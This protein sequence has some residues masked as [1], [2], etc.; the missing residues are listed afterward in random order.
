MI[1]APESP[2]WLVRH[3]MLAEAERSAT[4]LSS[5]ESARHAHEQVA[6][7]VCVTKLEQEETEA[8]GNSSWIELFK[9]RDLRGT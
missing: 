1:F 8:I 7:M 3:G 2:W 5:A 4:R 9:G 6:N